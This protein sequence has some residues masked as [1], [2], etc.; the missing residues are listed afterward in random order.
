MVYGL[1]RQMKTGRLMHVVNNL[2]VIYYAFL[3]VGYGFLIWF[4]FSFKPEGENFIHERLRPGGTWSM[5]TFAAEKWR[6]MEANKEVDSVLVWLLDSFGT[7]FFT[8]CAVTDAFIVMI[9]QEHNEA[10]LMH[11]ETLKKQVAREEKRSSLTG[12][13]SGGPSD[14]LATEGLERQE[15]PM[16]RRLTLHETLEVINKDIEANQ[17]T[18]EEDS[19]KDWLLLIN[20]VKVGKSMK[21]RSPRASDESIIGNPA[22]EED[23][24]LPTTFDLEE[25]IQDCTWASSPS[26]AA[27]PTT[28][29]EPRW[30]PDPKTTMKAAVERVVQQNKTNAPQRSNRLSS[31]VELGEVG[32]SAG[33]GLGLESG[34]S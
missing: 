24:E 27:R 16:T 23:Q 30:G 3:A 4:A 29:Q 17:H 12:S 7:F 19:I 1:H 25:E 31:G 22:T 15:T 11:R 21:R 32:E 28:R 33:A 6:T 26:A 9:S 5:Q 34:A 13:P 8:C 20:D 10:W 18:V 2:L 14:L